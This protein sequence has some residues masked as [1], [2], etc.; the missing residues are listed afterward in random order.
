MDYKVDETRINRILPYDLQWFAKDGEGGEKTEPATQ[1]KLTDARKEGKVAKSKELTAAFDLV[2]LFLVLKVFISY[3]GERLLAIFP[4][5]YGNMADFLKVNRAYLSAQAVSSLLMS[6]ILKWLLIV[7]PFFLF[8][9]VI[10]LLISVFQVGWKVSTKPMQPKLDKFNPINGFK[11]I[12]SKDSLFNLLLA[13]VKIVLIAITAYTCIKNKKDDLFILYSIPLKQA[14]ALIGGI[15]IDTGLRISIVY[16]I[17]GIADYIYQKWKFK[18]EMKMTK[19]EVK[20]EYKNTEGD[21]QIKGRQRRKMQEAS[22]RRMMQ[23]VPKAD[24]VIT[25]PTHLAVALQYDAQANRAPVLLAKGEDYVAQK[26]KEVAR[27]HHIEIVENKPL[28][29]MI[30]HNVDIGSEIPPELYQSVA[31]VLAMVYHTKNPNG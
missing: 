15:I 2:V 29:R 10:T 30:Y 27:E 21:P 28:A 13:L 6:I 25:N 31:E 8:G 11:R 9:V 17:V 3:V 12:F 24:V 4:Y 23:D 22:Q 20:D 5:V 26:I 14:V 19:Q 1:K 18:D 7:L 16:M